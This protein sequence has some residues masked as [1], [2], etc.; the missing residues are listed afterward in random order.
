V[1]FARD[2]DYSA[3][4]PGVVHGLRKDRV[5]AA[6][7]YQVQRASQQKRPALAAFPPGAS[8]L[9]SSSTNRDIAPVFVIHKIERCWNCGFVDQPSHGE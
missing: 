1:F 4:F 5:K 9:Q 8:G 3:V 2:H 6:D 7:P